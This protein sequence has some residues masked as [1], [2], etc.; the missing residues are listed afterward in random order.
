MIEPVI[1]AFTTSYR[2]ARRAMMAMMS[3]AALPKVALSS[4]P[5]PSPTLL[6]EVLG[7]LAHEAR[8][9]NDREAGRHEDPFRARVHDILEHDGDGHE[10]QEQVQDVLKR[11]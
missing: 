11:E 3:S 5:T 10:Q 9:R 8:E 2:P 6:G 4:P 7:R 1:D